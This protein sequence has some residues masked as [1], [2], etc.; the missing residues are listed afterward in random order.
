[1]Q[2][3][4]IC[5]VVVSVLSDFKLNLWD[6][7][8]IRMLPLPTKSFQILYSFYHPTLYCLG[9]SNKLLMVLVSAGLLSC[10]SRGTHGHILL[11]H[12]SGIVQL[13]S[14]YYQY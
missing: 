5:L 9:R 8:S 2:A 4:N 7:T 11:S 10:E 12:D 14:V 6:I 3:E 1:M 13:P